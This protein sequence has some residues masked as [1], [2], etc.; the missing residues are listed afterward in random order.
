M[1]AASSLHDPDQLIEA[2]FF[3]IASRL[4]RLRGIDH[5]RL[6]WATLLFHSSQRIILSCMMMP[7]AFLH[8]HLHVGYSQNSLHLPGSYPDGL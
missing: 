6:L 1:K 3:L 5:R 2:Q 7:N 8:V 4:S